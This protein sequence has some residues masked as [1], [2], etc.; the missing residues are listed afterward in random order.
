MDNVYILILNWN[1]WRDTVECLESVLRNEYPNYRVILC[2]NDSQD[3]S[4]EHI[5]KW[6]DGQMLP[7]APN[8][9]SIR[10]LSSPPVPKPV[11][12]VEY[13]RSQ[14]EAGGKTTDTDSRLILI[15]TGA[16]L[17]FAGG[18]NVG[19]RYALAKND[20]AYVWLLNNDTVIQRDALTQMVRRMGEKPG[21]GMCGSTVPFYHD[22]ERLWALGG[23]RY[24]RWLARPR[25]IG[26]GQPVRMSVDA[27]L[28]ERRMN[29]VA[30]ASMLVSR[31]FLREVGLLSE[32]YFLYYEELDWAVRA[33]GRF[34]LAFA[35][36]SL[37]YHKVGASMSQDGPN[38]DTAAADYFMF[39][40]SVLFTWKYFPYAMPVVFSR[41]AMVYFLKTVRSAFR[42]AVTGN[43][44]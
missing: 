34:G 9:G 16:N 3:D 29:F 18:N 27:D 22:P 13:D 10:F 1:G 35:P 8:N 12:Y 40:N 39:R 37:V 25:C 36:E 23:A 2:D 41:A 31:N 24:N 14:A 11:P 5:K 19:L 20:F 30:G 33:K 21:A 7:E 15:R 28:V 42:R 32:D 26:L 44:S 4:V 6:A 38:H 17:G 43:R